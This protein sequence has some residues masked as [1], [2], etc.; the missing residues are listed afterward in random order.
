M[1][2]VNKALIQ[3]K[4]ML[5]VKRQ[6]REGGDT[7]DRLDQFKKAAAL[8]ESLTSDAVAGMM[9]KHT[10]QLYTM[11]SL[12]EKGHAVIQLSKWRET[13]YDSIN[14]HLLLLAALIEEEGE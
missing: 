2:T 14:Y 10:A 4:R 5:D 3:C 11:I 8:R 9:V 12:N 13:I 7:D 6:Y 1:T